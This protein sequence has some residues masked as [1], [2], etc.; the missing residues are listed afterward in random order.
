MAFGMGFGMAQRTNLVA[1][2]VPTEDIGEASAILA[3]VRNIS[4]AFGIAIFSTILTNA[5]NSN[6]L[7][8]AQ[9]SVLNASASNP[10]ALQQFIALITLK[11]QVA[12]YATVFEVAAWLVIIGSFT[13]FLITVPKEN[14][15]KEHVVRME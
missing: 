5:L 4:G 1:V 12:S 2:A 7:Q 10:N 9:H 14:L 15:G 11:A 8:T 3:L 13:A 6:V